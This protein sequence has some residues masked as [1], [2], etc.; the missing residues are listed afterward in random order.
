MILL[1]EEPMKW[2]WEALEEEAIAIRM[3][4]SVLS[5]PWMAKSNKHGN[6]TKEYHIKEVNGEIDQGY[7]RCINK[8]ILGNSKERNRYIN[9]TFD[10][11]RKVC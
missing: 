10:I 7:L 8:K 11:I 3:T 5:N 9:L 4:W 6:V 1:K 2:H